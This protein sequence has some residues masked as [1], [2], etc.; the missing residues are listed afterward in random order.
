MH[1]QYYIDI[2]NLFI[3]KF[4]VV[5][6][7]IYRHLNSVVPLELF[8]FKSHQVWI[9]KSSFSTDFNGSLEI[10]SDL[11]AFTGKLDNKLYHLIF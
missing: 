10:V 5:F 6:I 11:L 1:L 2:H 8:D 7:L 4:A 3:F 9:C